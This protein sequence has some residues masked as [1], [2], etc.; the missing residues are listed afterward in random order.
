MLQLGSLEVVVPPDFIS[1]E[2]SGDVMVSE[3]GTVKLTC[4]AKGHPM[5][6]IQWR[7]EDG[8][9]ITI[10]DPSGHRSRGNFHIAFTTDIFFSVNIYRK[11]R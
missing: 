1:E 8:G 4:K 11:I 2:T 6:H 9:E 3:G 10:R 7:K 5:P